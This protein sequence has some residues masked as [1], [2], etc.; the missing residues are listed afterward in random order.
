MSLTEAQ[1]EEVFRRA[2]GRCE[3]TEGYCDRHR[4]GERCPHPLSPGF[5][6]AIR[7]PS[8]KLNAAEDYV[9]LCAACL[10]E[11]AYVRADHSL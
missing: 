11:T 7:K 5:W 10:E 2:G 9:G 4:P 6:D 3:C 8:G 1:R